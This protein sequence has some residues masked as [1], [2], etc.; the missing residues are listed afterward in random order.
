MMKRVLV[1]MAVLNI[2]FQPAVAGAGEPV[3]VEPPDVKGTL[4]SDDLVLHKLDGRFY[5]ESWFILLQGDDGSVLMSNLSVSNAGISKWRSSIDLWVR[6]EEETTVKHFE[7]PAEGLSFDPEG[8]RV[9]MGGTSFGGNPPAY[10]L[11]FDE[12]GLDGGIDFDLSETGGVV[13]KD[14]TRFGREGKYSAFTILALG[15]RTSGRLEVDGKVFPMKGKAYV[16]HHNATLLPTQ[17]CTSWYSFVIFHGDISIYLAFKEL[18]E[19]FDESSWGYLAVV[20][21]GRVRGVVHD[22]DC[23]PRDFRVSGESGHGTAS[24]FDIEALGDGFSLVGSMNLSEEYGWIDVLR[25]LDM[26]SRWIVKTFITKPWTQRAAYKCD[27]SLTID[28]E[29]I[30]LDGLALADNFFSD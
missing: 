6:G 4:T 24:G 27:L 21:G 11:V 22:F 5:N 25:H 2:A 19:G 7:V 26:V 9:T 18:R 29:K 10:R 17:Y 12:D 23:R 3:F 1:V 14:L 8:N 13:P 16:N 15:A 30:K 28:G 20:R